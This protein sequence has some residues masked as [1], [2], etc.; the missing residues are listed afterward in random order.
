[1]SLP[2][3][4]LRDAEENHLVQEERYE[5]VL[6]LDGR[7]EQWHNT[8]VPVVVTYAHEDA[9]AQAVGFVRATARLPYTVLLYNIGLKPYS[10]AVVS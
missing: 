9:L 6:G 10:L 3:E 7:A 2:Q 4:N 5:R 8:S 1:M